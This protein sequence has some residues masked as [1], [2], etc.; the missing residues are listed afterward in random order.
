M[1]V[2]VPISVCADF[3]CINQPTDDREAAPIALFKQI[4]IAVGFYLISPFGNEYYSY[5]GVDCTEGQQRAVAWF[6]NEMLTL[7]KNATEYFETN[8]PLEIEEEE[9]FQQSKVCWLC[10]QALRENPLGEV[11]V[12]D[13]DHLTGTYRGAAH[14]RCN[15][16]C[17]KSR[18]RLFPYFS[19]IS[20]GMIATSYSKNS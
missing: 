20:V 8:I 3:E 12:R 9:S 10:E 1:N 11:T 4:P 15:L 16:N 7:E 6:V 19:I 13:H 18:V 5:I 2:P 14:N 17:K